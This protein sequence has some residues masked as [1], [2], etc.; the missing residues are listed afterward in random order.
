MCTNPVKINRYGQ[1][2]YTPCGHCLQCLKAYQDAWCARLNEELKM[3]NKV[4]GIIPC[5][6]F[7]LDYNPEAI[8]CTYLVMSEQGLYLT[9]DKPNCRILQM[10]TDTTHESHSEWLVRRK[11]ILIEY[12]QYLRYFNYRKGDYY[13]QSCPCEFNID[14]FTFSDGSLEHPRQKGNDFASIIFSP[15]I[16]RLSCPTILA[17]SQPFPV[18]ALE[19]H[20]V[21]KDDVQSWL[22]RGR[23]QLE[24]HLPDIF[25]CGQNPRQKT[26]WIN[27][28]DEVPFP[29]AALTSTVKY[30]ITS[31][32]GPKTN[33]PHYHGVMF[34]L[35]YDEFEEYFAKDWSQ[36]GRC[37]FSV[38]YPTGGAMLYVAK[39]CSK[40]QYE[41]PYCKKDYFYKD[42]EY[43]SR[44]FEDS[45]LDF[46]VDA[47]MVCPTFHL[48]SKGLGSCYCFDSA[49]LD[50]VGVNMAQYIT[51][52]GS[53]RYC[54]IDKFPYSL[55]TK[56]LEEIFPLYAGYN[57]VS[58]LDI[59]FTDSGD[60]EISRYL[61][62]DKKYLLS[63]STIKASAV[64]DAVTQK[65]VSSIKYNRSYVKS[66]KIN[67]TTDPSKWHFGDTS[68][69]IAVSQ[70]SISLP[71]YYQKILI[72]P[73]V[74]ALR[75]AN[76][77]QLF[78][79]WHV[80]A[81]RVVQELGQNDESDA[82]V[83]SLRTTAEIRKETIDSRLRRSTEH[84]ISTSKSGF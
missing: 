40:G 17:V 2:F 30:F 61:D 21:S 77:E 57:I 12:W 80:Q 22:K 60:M 81:A 46:G 45:K 54:S 73:L 26:T 14:F 3:W 66:P 50:Y 38:L 32:Y 41:H 35:T 29:S 70:T 79:D 75:Q 71:R 6:Y 1:T 16:K 74:S 43:H 47:A 10:W 13:H 64:V 82:F 33:R 15:F 34:G 55:P 52:S 53:V 5:I 44:S 18:L 56:P 49:I 25:G 63:H 39:Y 7:T 48:V 23:R 20:S 4:D 84:F 65:V 51:D 9:Y 27:E 67:F 78:A 19:F 31:E 59:K 69:K 28:G 8:P 76:S 36:Y 58:T 24:Y 62:K 37:V 11:S 42:T 72:S 68:C 83:K